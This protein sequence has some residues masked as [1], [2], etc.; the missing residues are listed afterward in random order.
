MVDYLEK[1]TEAPS[2]AVKAFTNHVKVMVH[3]ISDIPF[4][5]PDP[6]P[7]IS[8]TKLKNIVFHA[9]LVS[10]QTNLR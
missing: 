2:M 9:M 7:T 6:A 10:W 8:K 3:Y 1:L 5:G 4:L